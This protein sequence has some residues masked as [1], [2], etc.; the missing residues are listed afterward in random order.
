MKK[1]LPGIII[2]LT[3]SLQSQHLPDKFSI[4]NYVEVMENDSLLIYFNCTGTIVDKRCAQF[5]RTGKMDSI[6]INLSGDFIDYYMNG[7]VALKASIA[8]DYLNGKATYYFDHGKI[9][10]TGNYKQDIKNGVWHYYYRNGQLEKVINF[11]EGYPFIV[12]YYKKNGN[13]KVING[14][15]EYKGD[16][17][18]YKACDPYE[19][20]GPVKNGKL[21][22][23]WT[24]YNSYFNI[25]IGSEF[26]EDGS[27]LK[28]VSGNYTY[29][30][31]P[32]VFINDFCPHENLNLQENKAGCPGD[33]GIFWQSYKG[34]R[35]NEAFYPDLLDSIINLQ[36]RKIN[37][38][39]LII[40]LGINKINKLNEINVKSSI[41]DELMESQ[42]FKILDSMTDFQSLKMGGKNVDSNLFFTILIRDNRV[43]IPSDVIY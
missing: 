36:S 34:M 25:H 9:K 32:K 33:E 26:Y 24:L 2:F 11:V 3:I 41:N 14:N 1:V 19:I 28:G 30:E 39:W 17:Y 7:I 12:D 5:Y 35:L 31:N 29:T 27:F 42:V 38:Q 16:C 13:Q 43:V 15:G 21:D 40:G 37:N 4:G 22:G 10:A 18:A 20:W 23:E 6:N 8:D